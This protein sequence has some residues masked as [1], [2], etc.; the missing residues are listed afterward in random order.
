MPDTAIPRPGNEAERLSALQRYGILDTPNDPD[1][2]FLTELA[3]HVCDAPYAFVVMVDAERVWLKSA[4][5]LRAGSQRP[6][7]QDYC[8]WT[9]LEPGGLHLR[10]VRADP[11]TAVLAPTLDMGYRMYS[12]INLHVGDGLHIGTLCV[13]DSQPRDLSDTQR[14]LLQRLGRQVM[15][16]IELRAARRDLQ[17]KV[18][19]LDRLSRH[20]E[21][22]G[23]Y[24]R[25]ALA[26]AL[27]QE[28]ARA[29]R[30]GNP[31]SLMLVDVDHF[32]GI[33]DGHGHAMGDEV[34]RRL[35]AALGRR[36]RSIDVLGRWGGEEFIV[37]M[38]QTTLDGALVLAEAARRC[39]AAL[40]IPGLD[41]RLTISCGVASLDDSL[42][43]AA[44]LTAA[45]DQALY[46]AKRSGR[47]RVMAARDRQALVA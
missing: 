25:R 40:Q 41:R 24:N 12:G 45:A 29:R 38:P 37:V 10:D 46:E 44:A 20:D 18:A 42:D 36:A 22:T 15:A 19:A 3:A 28:L 14:D 23:L 5:G 6:R 4:V 27:D 8:A 13:L 11:R 1:F 30:F 31:L 7:D 2:D 43:D 35:A 16:L 26:Q 33:N 9:I 17:Q 32:K 34:L 47:N 39:V 21:L